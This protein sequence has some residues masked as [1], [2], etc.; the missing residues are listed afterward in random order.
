MAELKDIRKFIADLGGVVRVAHD[1]YSWRGLR[2]YPINVSGY[3]PVVDFEV[4]KDGAFAY[5]AIASERV[6]GV[7][8][9]KV[10]K[11]G[12]EFQLYSWEGDAT[13]VVLLRLQV[14]TDHDRKL[15]EEW[16]E[17]RDRTKSAALL[18]GYI[19]QLQDDPIKPHKPGPMRTHQAAMVHVAHP[20]TG[21]L[22]TMAAIG[23]S[24]NEIVA[25]AYPGMDSAAEVWN[26]RFRLAL[27]NGGKPAAILEHWLERV[28]GNTED[29]SE[30]FEVEAEDAEDAAHAALVK[31][32]DTIGMTID[33]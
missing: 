3:E 7:T 14:P 16:I 32:N 10:V 27:D 11:A 8:V 33:V 2:L 31:Y 25:R 21:A 5:N 24:K 22:T 19:E 20:E 29:L 26:Q 23:A 13:R 30:P 6:H 12:D 15:A 1:F 28:N 17:V 18:K 4:G 9:Y